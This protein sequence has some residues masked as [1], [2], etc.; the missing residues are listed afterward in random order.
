MA[1]PQRFVERNNEISRNLEGHRAAGVPLTTHLVRAG[2]EA[3]E[4]LKDLLETPE[5]WTRLGAQPGAAAAPEATSSFGD[6][7]V[8][9]HVEVLKVLGHKP[10]PPAEELVQRVRDAIGQRDQ[11]PVKT[12]HQVHRHVGELKDRLLQLTEKADALL[13]QPA[14]PARPAAESRATGIGHALR[15]AARDAV[16]VTSMVAALL[17]IPGAGGPVAGT[18]TP[19]NVV[20]AVPAPVPPHA[21]EF[22]RRYFY[23]ALPPLRPIDPDASPP[24]SRA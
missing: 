2:T 13:K 1:T 23:R 18:G 24:G 19:A 15:E 21:D 16:A 7:V 10:P 14:S 3:Y 9:Y 20:Q 6:E 11:D 5:F 12:V 4:S 22:C 8:R 17:S